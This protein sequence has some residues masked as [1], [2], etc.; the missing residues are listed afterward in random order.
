[1]RVLLPAYNRSNTKQQGVAMAAVEPIEVVISFDTT[2]SMYPCL[3]QLRRKADSAVRRL[4]E[5][6][7]G[8]RVGVIAHGDYCDDGHPYVLKKLELT[9]NQKKVLD[10]VNKVEATGGGDAP[11]CYELA[12][13]ESRSMGWTSGKAKVVVLIGD[14]VP[15]GPSYPMNK[16]KL[17]WRNELG[18]LLE[19]GIHVYGV[20]A[21]PGIRKHSKS[22]YEE[23]AKKTGGFY[24]TLDQFTYITDLILAV[25]Y[26]QAGNERLAAYEE[27]VI[28]E[29][30][31]NGSIHRI[32]S[33]ML[34]R[35]GPAASSAADL[36][37]VPAGRF[38]V[39]DVDSVMDIRSFIQAQGADFKPGRGFY[40]LTKSELVQERKEVILMD[41][42]TGDFYSG[43][44]AREL[45]GL[46]PGERAKVRPV[47]L[48]KYDVFI[49][50]TSFNRK[51]VAGT[52][53]LYEVP[54][55]ERADA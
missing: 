18:L 12:L 10:F 44:K 51:L 7:P 31:M 3:T 37:A 19:A 27:E 21:M 39:L 26:K 36:S 23:M 25:A 33:T 43:D 1:V 28:R 41:K 54:D 49:Q 34:G 55:W 16:Q 2:G 11:E 32:F 4:F 35:T 14:D 24:L 29:K 40:Q 50:S 8:L 46:A 15:H 22:F 13:H 30:R 52:K 9:D 53:L 42:A 38:Q 17:D 20:H 6:I 45:V 48:D 5:E 47:T